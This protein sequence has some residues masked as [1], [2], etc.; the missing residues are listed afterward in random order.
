MFDV[1]AA[2][3]KVSVKFGSG[4]SWAITEFYDEANPF[5][6]DEI[7]VADNAVSLN[8][9]AIF[10]RKPNLYQVTLNVIP[11]SNDDV[12]LSKHLA[13]AHISPGHVTDV[14]ELECTLSIYIP[15]INASGTQETA[16]TQVYTYCNGRLISGNSGPSTNAE[17][18]MSSKQYV[19]AFESMDYN[20]V[21]A[22]TGAAV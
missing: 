17:G 12:F 1:S 4:D 7:Q 2:G 21:D 22:L 20:K 19:F 3:S 16:G 14:K 13:S 9:Q 5:E 10:W 11:G 8:G 15:Y 6:T 18:K